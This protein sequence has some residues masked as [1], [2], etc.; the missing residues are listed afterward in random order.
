MGKKKLVSAHSS[1]LP[2]KRTSFIAGR[3]DNSLICNINLAEIE[4]NSLLDYN[5]TSTSKEVVPPSKESSMVLVN[6]QVSLK[7][8]G[9]TTWNLKTL[10]FNQIRWKCK[11]K[12]RKMLLEMLGGRRLKLLGLTSLKIIGRWKKISS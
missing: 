7:H 11:A 3:V 6:P 9:T 1:G 12:N 10:I 8:L 5:T 4:N 2:S